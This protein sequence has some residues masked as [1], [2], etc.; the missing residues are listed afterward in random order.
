M[1]SSAPDIHTRVVAP[2]FLTKAARSEPV[3]D[4][5]ATMS[6]DEVEPPEELLQNLNVKKFLVKKCRVQ[7]NFVSGKMRMMSQC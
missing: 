3:L 7:L 5:A 2:S 4:F 6:D 1:F